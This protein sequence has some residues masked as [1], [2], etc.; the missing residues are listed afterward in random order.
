MMKWFTGNKTYLRFLLA[1]LERLLC[2]SF[3]ASTKHYYADCLSLESITLK[4]CSVL[5][6]FALQKPNRTSK[7]KV[8]VAHL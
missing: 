1:P 4:A 6:A 2:W 5:I 7:S 8:H 3:L